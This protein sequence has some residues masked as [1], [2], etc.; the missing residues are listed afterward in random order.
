MAPHPEDGGETGG[1]K[2][3]IY[4]VSD[5]GRRLVIKS[6]LIRR[7][8][9]RAIYLERPLLFPHL[10]RSKRLLIKGVD[11]ISRNRTEALQAY[12]EALRMRR[13]EIEQETKEIDQRLTEAINLERRL[14]RSGR[15]A[16]ERPAGG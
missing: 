1:K 10:F 15:P 13:E 12:R 8:S 3:R 9:E 14:F 2:R 11:A 5:A 4:A 6:A 7:E 16:S